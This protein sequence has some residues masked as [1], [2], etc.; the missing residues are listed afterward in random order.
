M[1]EKKVI[2]YTPSQQEVIKFNGSKDM[3]VSA[4]AGTGKTTIMIECIAKQ[5]EAG[6]DIS[7][8]VVVTFTNLAAAEMKG[9]LADRLAKKRD[10]KH[11]IEQL[12]RIDSAS[13][14]TLHSFCSELLRNYFYVADIDPSYAILDTNLIDKLRNDAMGELFLQYFNENDAVFKEVYKIFSTHRQQANFYQVL[15]DLYDFSRCIPNFSQ[16]Y[17]QRRDNLLDLRDDGPVVSE[18]LQN[19]R[20]NMA[21]YIAT[22]KDICNR[23]EDAGEKFVIPLKENVEIL[24]KVRLDTLQNALNDLFTVKLKA[25]PKRN[26]DTQFGIM[27]KVTEEQQRF[28]FDT[29]KDDFDKFKERFNTLSRGLSIETLK[30]QTAQ[31]VTHIDKLVE[32]VTRFD[33]IYFNFKKERGG[34]DFNDLEHITLQILND[35]EALKQIRERY[36]LVFVDEYQDTN[37]VQE[38]IISKL[39]TS[40]NLFMVGDVKQSIYGFRGCEPSI[41]ADKQKAFDEQGAGTVVKLND[42]FRSN[43]HILNFVNEVF[44]VIMTEEFGKVNYKRDAQLAGALPPKLSAPSTRID[45]IIPQEKKKK[46]ITGI[47]DITAEE[48]QSEENRQGALIARNIKQYVG[49]AYEVEKNGKKRIE[50]IEYKDIVILF[51]SLQGKALN[52]YNA[53]IEANIP[54]VAGFNVDGYASKEIKDLINLMRVLDNPYNDIYLVGV[55]LSCFGNFTESELGAIRLDTD[56][57]VPFYDRL[58]Q[59]ATER[60]DGTIADKVDKLLNLLAKL[61]FYSRSAEVSELVLKTMQLTDYQLYVQGLPNSGLR[62]RKLYNFVDSIKGVSYAQSIDRFLSYIDESKENTLDGGVGASN[63]VRIMTMHASKGL[64]F[65]IVILADLEHGFHKESG[66]LF[67]NF[68]N[69][70]A[71]R[72]YDF[73]TMTYAPTLATMAYKLRNQL[74]EHEEEMRLLYVATTRAKYALNI[75]ATLTEKQL[76]GIAK[77]PQ[78]ANSHLDWLLT[79]IKGKMGNNIQELSKKNNSR[80]G[81]TLRFI[82]DEQDYEDINQVGFNVQI[83]IIQNVVASNNTNETSVNLVQNDVDEQ[84]I[85]QRIAYKYKY[86]DQ[87]DMPSKVVSSALDKDYIDVHEQAE[88]TL[89]KDNDRNYVGT[90]YHKVYQ[91]VDYNADKTQIEQ[92]IQ[93]LVDSGIVEKRFADKLD[94]NLIYDTLHNPQ[95]TKIVSS[96]KVYHELPFMLYTP[97]NVVAKSDKYTDNVML[98]GVIDLLVIEGE[99]ATVVDFKYTSHSDRVKENY[100]AQLNSYKLAVQQICGIQNVDCYILSIADN[101]LIKM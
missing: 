45:F 76:N 25:L 87:A 90:A 51:R 54:V 28:N 22:L 78:N 49:M 23:F 7:Q 18:L 26:K 29:L 20:Q 2:D 43:V 55:C 71:M 58:K 60:K 35:D 27:E 32:I 39:A 62:I 44:N 16:W 53:L 79:A 77:L 85:L 37:P 65:P 48:E 88:V 10:D 36:K 94:V 52:V 57:R 67:C 72:R 59:Y 95:L 82:G 99:H 31:T 30:E 61:R 17:E 74:K 8:I 13:I 50:H 6:V 15:F 92:T 46:E 1:S 9:R 84:E 98:Q 34:V 5:I 91:Y 69:G 21:Y 47:Y 97:Y 68:E 66:S 63:A 96:G 81:W 70:V 80:L 19:I 73:D 89:V 93:S 64:Q 83:N 101:K 14:C 100:T 42:N 12:E 33:K 40:T 38:A 41:F 3:L 24:T 4:S 11:V 56:G 75:V 86:N